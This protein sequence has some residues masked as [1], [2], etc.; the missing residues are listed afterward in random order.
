M[1]TNIWNA[2]YYV[3]EY[4]VKV[5]GYFYNFIWKFTSHKIYYVVNVLYNFQYK[6]NNYLVYTGNIA[7]FLSVGNHEVYV[8]FQVKNYS[9]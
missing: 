1:L 6:M 8:V 7:G 4:F 2:V 9:T 5:I 3:F